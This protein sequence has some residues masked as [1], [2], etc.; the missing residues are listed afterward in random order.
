VLW[1]NNNGLNPDGTLAGTL[2]LSGTLLCF[3]VAG[4]TYMADSSTSAIDEYQSTNLSRQIGLPINPAAAAVDGGGN[5]YVSFSTRPI[6]TAGVN[7]YAATGAGALTPVVANS[8][9]FGAPAVDAAGN[10]YAFYPA[11]GND[12]IGVWPAGAFDVNAAPKYIPAPP[13][14]SNFAVTPAGGVYVVQSQTLTPGY[15]VYYAAPGAASAT[16]QV[17]VPAATYAGI[18]IAT[19]LR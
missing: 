12:A 9:A 7:Q 17:T 13:N 11:G 8:N 2:G 4:N 1:V 5:L 19:P 14:A 10:L 3:D 15:Q 18:N 16:P 6:G